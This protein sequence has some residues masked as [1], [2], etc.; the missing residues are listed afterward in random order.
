MTVQTVSSSIDEGIIFCR[1]SSKNAVVR[2]SGSSRSGPKGPARGLQG[3][4]PLVCALRVVPG[5]ITA[6]KGLTGFLCRGWCHKLETVCATCGYGKIRLEGVPAAGNVPA[7][8]FGRGLLFRLVMGSPGG[9]PLRGKAWVTHGSCAVYATS[10]MRL[11]GGTPMNWR[12]PTVEY[13]LV[14]A[15]QAASGGVMAFRECSSRRFGLF[16]GFVPQNKS[17]HP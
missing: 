9:R 1:L 15:E 3:S 7:T 13:S 5:A 12:R 4:G 10:N 2:E 17:S 8:G 6:T 11:C 16:G 14:A